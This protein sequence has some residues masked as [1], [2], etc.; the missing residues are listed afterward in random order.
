RLGG[1][2]F[3]I[4]MTSRDPEDAERLARRLVEH[5]SDT[6]FEPAGKITISVGLAR[7]PEHAMNPREL[8]AC[9]EAAMMTAKARG[10]NQ[11]F[12]YEEYSLERPEGDGDL[13]TRDVRSIA[14]MK[15]LQ[16][17]GG[18]LNRLNDV[19]QIANVIASELRSLID[20]HNCRVFVVEG[21]DVLPIAFVGAFSGKQKRIDVLATKVGDGFTGHVAKTGESLLLG[22]AKNYEHSK[23]LPGT[24]PIDESVI[25][26]ALTF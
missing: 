22:D 16:S 5:V 18:K 7:G 4:V 25:A 12:L 11:I 15:M 19:R 1:E 26:V 23:Q 17:L 2:E 10:K 3:A 13:T 21:E 20:Y 24:D 9:A 8:I 6:A 14:H